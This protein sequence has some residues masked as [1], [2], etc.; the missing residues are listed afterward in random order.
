MSA[1]LAACLGL[2]KAECFACNCIPCLLSLSVNG[3][4]HDRV[5]LINGGCAETRPGFFFPSGLGAAV[6]TVLGDPGACLSVFSCCAAPAQQTIVQPTVMCDCSLLAYVVLDFSAGCGS[7]FQPGFSCYATVQMQFLL[8]RFLNWFSV[9]TA[10]NLQ[11]VTLLASL[12]LRRC[13]RNAYNTSATSYI[14]I[15]LSRDVYACYS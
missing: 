1:H 15:C 14:C 9:E 8:V 13:P 12:Y 7:F 4:Q 2:Y 5:V 3:T 11:G 6:Y 10:S